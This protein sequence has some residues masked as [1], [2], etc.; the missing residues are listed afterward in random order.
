MLLLQASL[1]VVQ[2][3]RRLTAS[4]NLNQARLRL[5]NQARLRLLPLPTRNLNQA[6]LRLINQVR[7]QL[8]IHHFSS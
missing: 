2:T 6:R 7:L 3:V 4:R 8:R 1:V 5:I